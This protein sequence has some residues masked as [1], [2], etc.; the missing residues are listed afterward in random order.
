[1]NLRIL[2]K[3]SK[4]AMPL[5]SELGLARNHWL[6]EDGEGEIRHLMGFDRKHMERHRCSNPD[7]IYGG[8]EKLIRLARRPISGRAFIAMIEPSEP[9]AGT[10]SI[11]WSSSYESYECDGETAWEHLEIHVR[12][13]VTDYEVTG[14]AEAGDTDYRIVVRERLRHP[15][16]VLR[17]A[18]ELVVMERA[19]NAKA[20]AMPR[21]NLFRRVKEAG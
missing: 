5:L 15:S 10:P 19:R 16:D 11:T 6:P 9:W 1:M 14:D 18:R 13:A 4:R 7:L 2:K 20:A 17:K 12:D 8:G 21:H 3:L